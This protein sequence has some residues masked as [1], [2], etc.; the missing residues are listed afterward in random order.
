MCIRPVLWMLML[1]AAQV[2][3]VHAG[4]KDGLI[5]YEQNKFQDCLR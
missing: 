3:L 5:A 4:Y 1:L 2:S